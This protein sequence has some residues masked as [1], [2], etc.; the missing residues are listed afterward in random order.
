MAQEAGRAYVVGARG[1]APGAG[2]RGA[3]AGACVVG[4]RGRAPGA[5]ETSPGGGPRVE[6]G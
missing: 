5:G 1:R 4:A 6:Q 2:R 3:A